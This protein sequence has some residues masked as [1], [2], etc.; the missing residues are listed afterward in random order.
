MAIPADI[1]AL[2]RAGTAIPAHPLALDA[3]KKL[4][5]RHQ[6]AL[7]RYY[8]DAGAGGIAVGVHSTQFQIR[9]PKI[10]L[11]EPVLRLAAETIDAAAAKAGR[12]V[13]RIAGVCGPTAQAV[14]EASLAAGL[15]YHAALL[16][17]AGVPG[18][19]AD[20]VAHC[21]AVAEVIPVIG[22]YLQP[23]V[24]GRVLPFAFWRDFAA[25]ANVI[26]IKMAPFNRYRTLDVVRGV[27]ASGRDDIALYTGN[28]DNIVADLVT[29][30]RLDGGR[31]LRVVG[32]LLGQW[33]VWT[34]AAV[35]LLARCR[36]LVASGAPIPAELL[37]VGARLT[38]ANAAVFDAANDFRGC[39]PGLHYILHG[40]GLIPGLWCLDEHEVLSPGQ[41]QEIDRVRHAY[42]DLIDDAFV[43]AHRD[44]WLAD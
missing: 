7:A 24:G 10:G 32:G 23:A 11:Y 26:G 33:C 2:F 28:D 43:A 17:L 9:D 40:Q 12:P 41:A 36:A 18:T 35:K 37:A 30:F 14:R 38:D 42:P 16:S 5:P 19:L 27:A 25:I 3:Q 15:G 4:S 29:P 31:E 34:Q 13:M 39:L 20:L 6:R 44:R 22:F 8:V 1:L 21:R